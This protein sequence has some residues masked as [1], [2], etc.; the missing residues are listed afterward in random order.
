[1][2]DQ[3][4]TGSIVRKRDNAEE[5]PVFV[6]LTPACDLVIRKDGNF[7]TDRILLIEIDDPDLYDEK[8]KV[9]KRLNNSLELYLHWLPKTD[10][11][12]GGFL[13]FRKV[14]GIPIE[15]YNKSYEK[16]FIQI[17][18]SFVKDIISRFSSFYARQGQPNIDM[19]DTSG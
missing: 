17:A 13:N 1:V 14:A 8:G 5:K 7:K 19:Q 18:P 11:F 9:E 10:R 2:S 16:P 4:Y 6:V 3:L 12:K 15:E